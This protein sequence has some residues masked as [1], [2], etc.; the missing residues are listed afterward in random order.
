M[1]VVFETCL[2]NVSKFFPS[3]IPRL[4]SDGPGGCSPANSATPQ[5]QYSLF[6]HPDS[7][8]PAAP[9]PR[10]TAAPAAGIVNTTPLARGTESATVPMSNSC[11]DD[12]SMSPELRYDQ[13]G[14]RSNHRLARK[15]KRTFV[16]NQ[17]V[18]AE[19]AVE[20]GIRRSP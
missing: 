7:K 12:S 4:G 19:A 10:H 13:K 11:K 9:Q 20:S 1:N 5:P 18:S 3:G 14:S 8:F 16:G 17:H 2:E 6:E 15:R